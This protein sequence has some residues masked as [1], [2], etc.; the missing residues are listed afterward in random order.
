MKKCCFLSV[1]LL[2]F[3]LHVNAQPDSRK[4]INIPGI[5]GYLTLKCDLH[6]HTVFSDGNVWPS[7]R[8]AEAWQEGL[9]VIAI[10]D[11]IEYHPHADDI[12]VQFGRAYE[13]AKP[14]A[15]DMGLLLIKAAEITR[16]MPPGHF[17]CLFLEDVA[18]LDQEDFW[19][20]IGAAV[21]QGAY[22][23]WNHPG[24]RQKDEIPIW[25]SE[26]DSLYDLGWMHGMEIVNG[27]SYYPLA[28]Q[29]CIEKGITIIGNSDVHNPTGFEYLTGG[30]E[31]RS[32]TLVF[33]REKNIE[34]VREAL[35]AGRTAVWRGD[36]LYG[37]PA[38]LKAIFDQSVR[39]ISQPVKLKGKGFSYIQVINESDIV[40]KLKMGEGL[41][42]FGYAPEIVLYPGRIGTM[43]LQNLTDGKEGQAD[44]S[45]PYTV[46]NLFTGPEENLSVTLDMQVNFIPED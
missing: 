4:V 35:L 16:Q 5:P 43:P 18:A 3:Q 25:F 22:I 13:I 8:V 17:N 20:S 26:H 9:D 2:I 27:G 21:D 23:F 42:G 32:L 12:P 37:K 34:S 1:A 19:A 28:Y 36:E 46:T 40:F 10:S 24:W 31:T 14:H 29:W 30:E 41:K 15:D 33:A 39:V 38:C 45:I 44:I 7:V 6:M 11:H